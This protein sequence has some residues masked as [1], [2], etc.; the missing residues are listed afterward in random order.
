MTRVLLGWFGRLHGVGHTRTH[1]TYTPIANHKTSACRVS[2]R[3]LRNT[4]LY[5]DL[6]RQKFLDNMDGW[7]GTH[8]NR[9]CLMRAHV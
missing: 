6:H 2:G 7:L 5:Q 3:A 4:T 9:D 8:E 1:T